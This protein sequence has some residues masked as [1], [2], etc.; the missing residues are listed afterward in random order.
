MFKNLFKPKW[1]S[2]KPQVRKLAIEQLNLESDDDRSTLS[3]LAREDIDQGVRKVA[4]SRLDELEIL[5]SLLEKSENDPIK[6]SIYH[7]IGEVISISGDTDA[8]GSE[9]AVLARE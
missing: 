8:N 9:V 3:L 2:Q 6:E 1:K 5:T 4:I 7:R